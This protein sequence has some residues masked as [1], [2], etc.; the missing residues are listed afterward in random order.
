MLPL[1]LYFLYFVKICKEAFYETL[2][3]ERF[4]MFEHF[5]AFEPF[6][7]FE[8]FATFELLEVC[9][10]YFTILPIT[11]QYLDVL[12]PWLNHLKTL[13]HVKILNHVKTLKH[14]KMLKFFLH[15]ITV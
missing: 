14:V 4:D 1:K 3:F 6:D 8:H 7:T 5:D 13:K 15:R 12:T 11:L 9:K 10:M 2:I